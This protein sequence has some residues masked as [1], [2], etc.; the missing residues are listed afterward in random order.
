V[1]GIVTAILNPSGLRTFAGIGLWTI[2]IGIIFNGFAILVSE[3]PP[4]EWVV[5]WLSD[6]SAARLFSVATVGGLQQ[7]G[8]LLVVA[9]PVI[10]AMGEI[11]AGR[12]PGVMD[13]FR[14]GY[15]RFR[16]LFVG[17]LIAYTAAGALAFWIIGIPLA[18]WL[19]IRWQFFGQAAVLGDASSGP[20]A[21][22]MSDAVVRGRWWR[23][24][25]ETVVFHLLA[26]LPGPII[27]LLL[28]VLA[29]PTVQFA[30]SVSSIIYAVTVPISV[31]GITL[32]YERARQPLAR[33]VPAG[34]ATPTAATPS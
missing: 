28:L 4:M 9:P 11:R 24:L 12:V 6:S 13:S 14:G 23:T 33:P 32:A 22:R 3:Q 5:D 8:M 26:L 1:V 18:I 34:P 27:G 20:D 25:G 10:H 21:V 17:L 31:I 2:P 16:P 29:S 15:H 30:N 19:S 7:A